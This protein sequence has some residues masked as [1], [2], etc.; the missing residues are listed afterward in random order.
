MRPLYCTEA[1]LTTDTFTYSHF[2][3]QRTSNLR[4]LQRQGFERVEHRL[5]AQSRLVVSG[6]SF[7]LTQS[8]HPHL[9]YDHKE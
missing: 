7:D 1:P 9:L 4:A 5:G 8:K 2:N 3:K 6:Q